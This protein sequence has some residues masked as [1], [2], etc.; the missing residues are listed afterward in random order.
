MSAPTSDGTYEHQVWNDTDGNEYTWLNGSW[1]Q[2]GTAGAKHVSG[3]ARNFIRQTAGT[4]NATEI[5]GFWVEAAP[6]AADTAMTGIDAASAVTGIALEAFTEGQF[7]PV[8]LS[9]ITV[10]TGGAFL[11][12]I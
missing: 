12:I 10:G 11:L 1:V 5:K 6:S 9:T 7:Y 2:T 8:H 3:L 4:Y